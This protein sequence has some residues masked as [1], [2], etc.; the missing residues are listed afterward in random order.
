M[1]I[2]VISIVTAST[3]TTLADVSLAGSLGLLGIVFLLALL[4]QKEI[5]TTV[6]DK[7][8]ERWSNALNGAILP[9]LVVFIFIIVVRISI[10]LR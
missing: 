8:M 1:R 7:K 10:A 2:I 3:V 5:S 4:V 6:A 9:L